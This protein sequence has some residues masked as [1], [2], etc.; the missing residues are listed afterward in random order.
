MVRTVRASGDGAAFWA[1]HPLRERLRLCPPAR[2]RRHVVAVVP[3]P[4][5]DLQVPALPAAAPVEPPLVPASPAASAPASPAPRPA[6]T[7]LWR[8]APIGR[9]RCA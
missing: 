1:T 6:A 4:D 5:A 2:P 8:R 9:A 7:H 3:A